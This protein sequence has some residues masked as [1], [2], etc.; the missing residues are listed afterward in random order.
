M[1]SLDV[2]AHVAHFECVVG[3]R[4]SSMQAWPD[5]RGKKE[6]CKLK[7]KN[8]IWGVHHSVALEGPCNEALFYF[9]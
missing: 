5:P 6:I 1:H 9:T 7:C 8:Y 2:S 3:S 4:H